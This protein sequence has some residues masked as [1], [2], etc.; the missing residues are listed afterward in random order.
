MKRGKEAHQVLS[1][2]N[3][4]ARISGALF[5]AGFATFSLIYCT[6]PLLPEFTSDFDV[7][8]ATSSLA[9]SLTTGCLAISIVCVGALSETWGRRGLMFLSMAGAAILN[10][11]S[12]A[13][14]TWEFLLATRSLEG[15]VLG[16]VPAVAM[17]YLSEEVPAERLGR[18]M[19]LYVG[20]TAFGGMIGRVA[21]GA[22]T[23]F[24]SWRTALAT[25]AA[26]DL[27]VAIIFLMLLPP[28]RNFV[29]RSTVGL[30][31]HVHAWFGHLSQIELPWIFATGFLAM[32]A[33]VTIY[34]YAGFRLLAPPY[35]LNQT[36]IGLIFLAYIFGV[37]A[38]PVAGALAEKYGRSLVVVAGGMIFVV[39]LALTMLESLL[40]VIAGI[41]VITVGFFVVHSVVS[42]WVGY[43]ADR[44]KSHATSLYLLSYYLGSSVLGSL[45]GWFWHV[46]GWAALVGFCFVQIVAVLGIAFHLRLRSA[47]EGPKS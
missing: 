37:F 5:L 1:P 31:V 28:S 46:S 17:A 36:Q 24:S 22:L 18:A 30:R 32:G 7:S 4:L 20:G 10:L 15:L 38:S 23:H 33:F 41:S 12:S 3:G 29:R 19:G 40:A 39:G 42:G 13:A 47:D 14:P 25:M 6:Q 27:F 8:P 35:S 21:I 45:G 2:S 16:G 11:I 44:N 43:L 34:N 9:L 26:V